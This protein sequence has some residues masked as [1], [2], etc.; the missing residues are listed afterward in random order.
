MSPSPL[1]SGIGSMPGSDVGEALRIVLGEI[2]DLPFL[3]ELPARGPSAGMV[4]RTLGMVQ[5]LGADLQ[6]VG[7]R[8]TDTA[9]RD[10]LRAR[11]LLGHDLDVLEE[12]AGS[13]HGRLKVQV[14]GPWTLAG[15]VERP[16]GDKVLSDHGARRDLAQALAEAVA[17][18]VEDVRRRVPAATVVVQVDEPLL[19]DVLAGRIPTA[20][21]F[22]RHRSVQEPE[23]VRA[24][25]WVIEAAH[26]AGAESA[27]HCCAADV[28]LST[29]QQTSAGAV[30]FDISLLPTSR[31]DDVA[32][33]IDSGRAIWPGLVPTTDPSATEPISDKALTERLLDWLR[34]IG[35]DHPAAISAVVVTPTCGLAGASPGWARNALELGAK[36]AANLVS[37]YDGRM[38]S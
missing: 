2:G 9:G 12:L 11:S 32:A 33:W 18:H 19:P 31:Y 17:R 1:A 13:H 6:P 30:S 24:L 5:E 28:P 15:T 35:F 8:L 36:V 27:V 20:S 29:L 25:G 4:G 38:E 23:A 26:G 22:G 16:R 37:E 14:T 34:S 3:P 21:G 7:W 10:Q